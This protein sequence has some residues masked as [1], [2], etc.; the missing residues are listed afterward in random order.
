[1]KIERNKEGN[2]DSYNLDLEQLTT[3]VTVLEIAVGGKICK[4]GSGTWFLMWSLECL[5]SCK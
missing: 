2:D 5:S 4:K 1:M 3:G